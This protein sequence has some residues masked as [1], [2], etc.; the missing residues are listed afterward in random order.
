[1]QRLVLSCPDPAG[2]A[3]PKASILIETAHLRQDKS[4]PG[5]IY[6]VGAGLYTKNTVMDVVVTSAMQKSCL[7]NTSQSSDYH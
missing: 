2:C 1:M 5:D 6:A 7:S 4:R 3:F